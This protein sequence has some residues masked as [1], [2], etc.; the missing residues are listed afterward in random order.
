MS[1]VLFL[2]FFAIHAKS[3]VGYDDGMAISLATSS[4]H[5][6]GPCVSY[7][8]NSMCADAQEQCQSLG[9]F[10]Q[11]SPSFPLPTT[12]FQVSVRHQA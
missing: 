2:L 1:I 8:L 3:G 5:M 4:M 9:H 11:I 12:T 7:A 10:S 6:S